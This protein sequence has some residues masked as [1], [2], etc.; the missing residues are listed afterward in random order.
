MNQRFCLFKRFILF[1]IVLPALIAPPVMPGAQGA[2]EAQGPVLV[3]PGLSPG[4]VVSSLQTT[5]SL[6]TLSGVFSS[7]PGYD[8]GWVDLAQNEV[9]TMMHNLGGSVDNYVV[10]MQCRSS[11]DGINQRYYGG[12]DFGA[13]PAPGHAADDRVGAYWRSLT[14]SSI[15]VFRRLEDSYSVQVRIRIWVDRLPNYNSGWQTIAVNTSMSFTHSLGGSVDDYVVDMQFQSTN[16]GINQRYFGGA[17]FGSKIGS[18]GSVD[19]RVGAYWRSLSSTAVSVY[20][21]PEDTYAEQV[22]IRIWV[23]PRP[24]YDSGWVSISK[25]VAVPLIHAVGQ[26]ADDYQV[27]MEFKASDVN[28]I[29]NRAYGGMD[30][31]ASPSAGQLENDRVGAYWRNLTSQ[32]LIIYRRP[33]DGFADSVRVRIWVYRWRMYLPVVL[34]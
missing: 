12:A 22:R 28:G 31:G 19:D 16:S 11:V 29:N 1:A 34:R 13:M 23:R 17:D 14:T 6:R 4:V 15:V 24:A 26:Q 27:N 2:A 25:D 3:E 32:S 18:I 10:D 7:S 20:R 9:K 5:P 30:V 33:E 21:R 8:S